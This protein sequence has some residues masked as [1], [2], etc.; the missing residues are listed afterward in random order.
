[1][2]LDAVDPGQRG[3]VV[4]LR[5]LAHREHRGLGMPDPLA[6]EEVR[7]EARDVV[8]ARVRQG[9]GDGTGALSVLLDQ[10][11]TDSLLEQLARDGGADLAGAEDDDV[12]DRGLPWCE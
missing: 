11:H 2:N 12:L 4:I 6:G 10:P 1:M 5:I 9:V 7:V 3:R 8:D